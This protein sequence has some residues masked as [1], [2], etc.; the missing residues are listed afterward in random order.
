MAKNITPAMK[1]F[2]K[3]N[4]KTSNSSMPG[5]E[6]WRRLR[7]NKLAMAG[8]VI[9]IILIIF[10]IVPG[11][12]CKYSPS[13]QNSDCI[14]QAPSADHWFGTDNMGRDIFARVIYGTR[15]SLVLGI[16]CVLAGIISGG[17]IGA[18]VAVYGGKVDS[19]IMRVMDVFQSIP[20]VLLAI[21][22]AAVLGQGTVNLVIAIAISTMP[23]Y[24]RIVRAAVMTVKN[25]EFIEAGRC[26]GASD[27]V[28][29][30]KHMIPNCLGPIITQATFGVAAA[31][32]TIAS[33]SYIGLGVKP[34][35]PEW[36]S[37][38]SDGKQYIQKCL[39]MI[40]FP[41][42]SI[43]LSSF[44]LNVLGDGLRDAFDPKLR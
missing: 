38:L 3:K 15:V 37:M 33:L 29:V 8:L 9:L 28:L 35:T 26:L 19:I 2:Q 43:L 13:Y 14:L 5:K 44:S 21:A 18:I 39:W 32:L 27:F 4:K 42:V 23:L 11:I 22:I 17:I 6:I 1:R 24:A 16:L 40:I 25:K 31:I 12:F 34:P 30:V 7:R 20:S 10:A 41:G 36:G